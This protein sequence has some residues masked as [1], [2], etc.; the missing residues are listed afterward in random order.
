MTQRAG[1]LEGHR[2]SCKAECGGSRECCR[3]IVR[4]GRWEEGGKVGLHVGGGGD[5]VE[6]KGNIELNTHSSPCR[7]K[8]HTNRKDS[9]CQRWKYR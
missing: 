3:E 7:L 9:A 2:G 1:Y 6:A 4:W 8:C 5:I